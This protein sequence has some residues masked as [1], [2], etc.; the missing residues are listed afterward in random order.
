M[1]KLDYMETTFLAV[2]TSE[3]SPAEVSSLKVLSRVLCRHFT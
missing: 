2:L 3:A 1:K